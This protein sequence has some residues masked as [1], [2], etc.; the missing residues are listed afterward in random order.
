MLYGGEC[1]ITWWR[2]LGY[3]GGRVLGYMVESV[4]LYGESV[5]LYRG[6]C[7]VTWWRVLGYMGYVRLHGGECCYLVILLLW[8]DDI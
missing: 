6:E 4:G 3:K 1:C 2:V 8:R 5:V 7:C